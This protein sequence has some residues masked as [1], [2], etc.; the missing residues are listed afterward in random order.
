MKGKLNPELQPGDKIICLHMEG[1]LGVPPG[2]LGEVRKVDRDPFEE[3]GKLIQVN[4]DNGSRLALVSSTDA[5]KKIPEETIQEAVDSNWNFITTNADVFKHFDWKW[6]RKFLLKIRNSG[7]VNMYESSP[8][9]YSGRD[10]IDRYY[11]EGKEDD[12]EFQEVL[13]NADTAKNKLIQGVV[14]YMIANDKNLDDMG[15]VNRYAR[16]FSQKL[17]GVYITFANMTGNL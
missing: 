12:E 11:G 16:H 9:L 8:L 17:L 14:D 7:I 4:W 15:L 6:F 10:H 2:T 13:E 1:E 5:W 3:D